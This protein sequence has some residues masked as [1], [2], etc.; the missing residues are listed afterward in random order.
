M[1]KLIASCIAVLGLINYAYS[2]PGLLARLRHADSVKQGLICETA[3]TEDVHMFNTTTGHYYM[4]KNYLKRGVLS[5]DQYGHDTYYLEMWVKM[6]AT[7]GIDSGSS[8][9]TRYQFDLANNKISV[10]EVHEYSIDGNMISSDK[11]PSS[12][13]SIIPESI[14]EK[15]IEFAKSFAQIPIV[16]N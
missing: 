8:C 6:E 5:F 9:I 13:I 15:L 10:R 11:E 7:T 14:G 16:N 2:Q 1:K 4:K 3:L 12:W